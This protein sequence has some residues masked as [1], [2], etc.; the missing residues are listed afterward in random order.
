MTTSGDPE[1]VVVLPIP[2]GREAAG[3]VVGLGITKKG[4][5]FIVVVLPSLEGRSCPAG[6]DGGI[7]V[8]ALVT[9][10]NGDPDMTVVLPDKP[11]GASPAGIVVGSGIIISV[12]FADPLLIKE[13]MIEP[14]GVVGCCGGELFTGGLSPADVFETRGAGGSFTVVGTSSVA[15]CCVVGQVSV[16]KRLLAGICVV[17]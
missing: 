7:M 5:P 10:V 13:F 8:V 12:G 15:G 14:I 2:L 16:D 6:G 11:G 4:V 17:G 3:I 9:T 1:I